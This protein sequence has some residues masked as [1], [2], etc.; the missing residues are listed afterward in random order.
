MHY[1]KQRATIKT[2]MID[3]GIL[4][5][6]KIEGRIVMWSNE[7]F[8]MKMQISININ[9][10]WLQCNMMWGSVSRLLAI[11]VMSNI[12]LCQ[13]TILACRIYMQHFMLNHLY[14][15]LSISYPHFTPRNSHEGDVLG[16][17]VSCQFRAWA[18]FCCWRILCDI[19]P[20]FTTV[21][22]WPITFPT[23]WNR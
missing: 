21:Y 12:R 4:K 6:W 5:L 18:A 11:K 13:C 10:K 17:A 15:A 7:P 9:G 22:P 1:S 8:E 3:R 23:A 20:Y 19:V 2:I 16:V 14:I